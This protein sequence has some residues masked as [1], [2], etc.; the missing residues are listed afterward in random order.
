MTIPKNIGGYVNPLTNGAL[1]RIQTVI[2]LRL[3]IFDDYA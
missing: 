3:D 2:N 1:G